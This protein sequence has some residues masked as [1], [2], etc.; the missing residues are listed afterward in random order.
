MKENEFTKAIKDKYFGGSSNPGVIFLII[1]IALVILFLTG[2]FTY[3]NEKELYPTIVD[4][5]SSKFGNE[6][7]TNETID[8]PITTEKITI[9]ETTVTETAVVT[10]HSETDTVTKNEPVY[11][12][13]IIKEFTS[14]NQVIYNFEPRISGEHW[15]GLDISTVKSSYKIEIYNQKDERIKQANSYNNGFSVDLNAGEVY[16]LVISTD[17]DNYPFKALIEIDEPNVT[18]VIEVN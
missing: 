6:V 17:T 16:Q 18:Q 3:I 4:W 2:F 15:F 5:I 14:D 12:K 11:F 10:T 7:T 1:I 9:E 13:N 8:N